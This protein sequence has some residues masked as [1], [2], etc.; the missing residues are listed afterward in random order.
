MSL[1]LQVQELS[2]KQTDNIANN[3]LVKQLQETVTSLEDQL[4]DKN[5]VRML[6]R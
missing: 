5:K 1:T 4:A 2:D 3:E 6:S